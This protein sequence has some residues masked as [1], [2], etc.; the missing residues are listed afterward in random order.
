MNRFLKL[1]TKTTCYILPWDYVTV[2][3]AIRSQ[4]ILASELTFNNELDKQL[5]SRDLFLL[6]TKASL[7]EYHANSTSS[8]TSFARDLMN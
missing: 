3:H 4:N 1:K 2:S 8:L 7:S 5:L 6:A